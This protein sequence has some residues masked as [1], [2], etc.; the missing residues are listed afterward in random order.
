MKSEN[1]EKTR[2][3]MLPFIHLDPSN[4]STIYTAV[5]VSKNQCELHGINT[6]FVTHLTNHYTQRRS[7]LL[8]HLQIQETQQSGL[9]VSIFSYVLLGHSQIHHGWQWTGNSVGNSGSVIHM[10]TGHAY[11]QAVQAHLLTSA[12]LHAMLL[13]IHEHLNDEDQRKRLYMFVACT[14][15]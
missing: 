11:F 14:S 8:L 3:E 13:S 5:C 10:M 6:C 1:H 9:V 4:P 2:A 7:K 12:A 15:N